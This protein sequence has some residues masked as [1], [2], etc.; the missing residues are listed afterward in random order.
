MRRFSAFL[1]AALLAFATLAPAAAE[2][3]DRRGHDRRY[4]RD[5][6]HDRYDR[7]R[8]RRNEAVAAGV[9]GLVLGVAIASAAQERRE[10]REAERAYE[11]DD[12]YYD[13]GYYDDDRSAYERDYEDRYANMPAEQPQC[14]RPERQWD[15]Y[16]NR[17]VT[18]DMPC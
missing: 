6:H 1:A 15:R 18:V 2:A 12:G 14:T 3:R 13:D 9:L 16:A 10:R 8:D 5:Y 11:R 4:E 17:Y 7:R